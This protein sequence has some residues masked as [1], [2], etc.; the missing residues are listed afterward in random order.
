MSEARPCDAGLEDISL[1]I[2]N[3]ALARQLSW[4]EHHPIHQK[5]AGSISGQVIYLGCGFSPGQGMYR[6]QLTHVSLFFPL[7]PRPSL[8]SINI[9]SGED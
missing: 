1:K 8:K 5:A 6:R 4:L 7:S 9:S 3:L 2:C